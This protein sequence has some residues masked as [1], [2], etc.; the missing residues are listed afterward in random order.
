MSASLPQPTRKAPQWSSASRVTLHKGKPTQATHA[1]L[2]CIHIPHLCG[3][4]IRHLGPP[5][6]AVN[7]TDLKAPSEITGAIE[8]PE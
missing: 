1:P 7:A 8:V 2:N 4:K 3:L 5:A 6:E